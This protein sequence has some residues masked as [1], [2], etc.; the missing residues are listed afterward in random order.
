MTV[1]A[2]TPARPNAL[3]VDVE[4]WFHICGVGGPLEPAHWDRLPSRVVETTRMLLDDFAAAG[5]R[6]TFFVLGWIAERHPRLVDEI[7]RAGHEVGSHGHTHTR[8]YELGP[9]GFVD[10]V[11]RSVAALTA[12]GAPGVRMFRA[13][14]WSINDRSIWALE[15]LVR[16]GFAVDASMAPLRIVGSVK[17]PRQPHVRHTAA[18]PILELPPFVTTRF[19][20]VMPLGW[21]W[22]LRMSSPARVL[23]T[24]ETANAARVPAVLTIHPWEIDPD[25]PR[26]ALPPRL[27]FAH[28]FRL[29]GFRQRL[30]RVLRDGASAR[31]VISPHPTDVFPAHPGATRRR[32]SPG[33]R[34]VSRGG[35]GPHCGAAAGCHRRHARRGGSG[36]S[37]VRPTAA[38]A[39]RGAG[40]R[41]ARYRRPRLGGA[42]GAVP[43]AAHPDLARRRRTLHR[44]GGHRVAHAAR[45]G[46]SRDSRTP[47]RFS[48]S[49]LAPRTR[50][51]VAFAVRV[52]ATDA[53]ARRA[54][55]RIALGGA[56]LRQASARLQ[57]YTTELAPYVD[58]L[59]IPADSNLASAAADLEA[60]DPSARIA[61]TGNDPGTTADGVRRVLDAH[62]QALGTEVV[63]HAW[64]PSA[65][66]EPGLRALSPIAALIT[67][68]VT[69]LDPAAATLSMTAG[70]RDV[71]PS[72][73]HRL[74]FEERTFATYLVYW[75]ETSP[76]RLQVSITLPVEGVP[77]VHRLID[78][79][80]LQASDY[81][82]SAENGRV[83]VACRSR[84][85]RCW[86]TSTKAPARS[87]SIAAASPPSGS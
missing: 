60:R 36:R 84:A 16:E 21:G 46:T 14:E 1:P 63:A 44:P 55:I 35:A 32:H 50:T 67:G 72:V 51:L 20:Q 81:S 31:S 58:L 47:R 34:D 65:A 30:T 23:R 42:A 40:G 41:G 17:Y 66:L 64:Q 59:A 29:G 61:L 54:S 80:R 76:D 11:R 85:A 48:R 45:R 4:D 75:S 19:G 33:G 83:R 37:A 79:S 26:V 87:S 15:L 49:S 2:D 74:L 86:W 28:Y 27:R 52:A 13:P 18:G 9:D 68:E 69:A 43:R 38:G 10:D 57:V 53:R 71:T 7:L 6:A 78:G 3:T 24:I 82:R 22:G 77:A 39:G 70:G 62:L 5:A 25:P 12:A 56:R 8:A 73:R